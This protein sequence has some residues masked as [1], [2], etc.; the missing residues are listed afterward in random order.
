MKVGKHTY[1]ANNITERWG[2]QTELIIGNFCSIASNVLVYLGGNH[3]I[4]WVTTYPFGAVNTEIF[5]KHNGE[6]HP[7]T[8]GNV[9]IGNDVWIGD[10]VTIMSGTRIGDGAVIGSNSVISGRIK[11]YSIYRGNPAEFLYFRFDEETISTLLQLKWWDL[12]DSIINELSPLLCSDNYDELFAVC[13]QKGL[14]N[15]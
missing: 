6:G 12:D 11:P 7:A 8:N 10:N 5:N 2:K 4:D 3:R 15:V 9:I 13:R 1:G 14:L